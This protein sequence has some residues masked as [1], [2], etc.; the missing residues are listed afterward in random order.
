MPAHARSWR[1]MLVIPHAPER[2]LLPIEHHWNG[3]RCPDPQ[4]RGVLSLGVDGSEL[5]IAAS[6]RRQR[7]ARLP[8][9]PQGTRVANLWEYDVVECFLVG[10]GGRYLE[11]ELGAA[12][13]FLVLEFDAPRRRVNE[14]ASL[15]PPLTFYEDALRWYARLRLPLALLPPGLQALNA[16]AIAGGSHFAH[17]AVPG[18]APDFHQ[19]DAFPRAVLAPSPR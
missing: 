8:A 10:A 16:F 11:V 9:A 7:P 12:G 4:R 19:P 14:F 17:H 5:E 6:F 3:T 18:A 13:H 1:R 2:L 15:A